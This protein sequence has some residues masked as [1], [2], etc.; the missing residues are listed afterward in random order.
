MDADRGAG[1]ADLPVEPFRFFAGAGSISWRHS[2]LSVLADRRGGCGPRGAPQNSAWLPIFADGQRRAAYDSGRN[3][4]GTCLAYSLPFV[5][6]RLCPGLWR[7]GLPG[8]DPDA[9]G[10]G[11]YANAIALNSIQFNVAV[12]VGPALAG[13]ALARLG[14]KWCFG[15]NALSFLAPI[16]SLSIIRAR[17]LPLKTTETMLTSLKQGIQFVRKQSSMEALIIL[18]FCMTALSM[19][20]RTYLPVFVKDIFHREIG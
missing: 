19:P 7:S 9:G 16:V 12:M 3:R 2:H 4:P 1:M 14:E 17:F 10:A 15:L 13:Q 20:M 6:L 11:R 8:A 5:C 18:A